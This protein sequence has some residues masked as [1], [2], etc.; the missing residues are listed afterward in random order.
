M[1]TRPRSSLPPW[2]AR[3][4]REAHFGWAVLWKLRAAEPEG[5]AIGTWSVA[6]ARY[7]SVNC[8]IGMKKGFLRREKKTVYRYQRNGGRG[9]FPTE[10]FR[11]TISP[12]YLFMPLSSRAAL[13]GGNDTLMRLEVQQRRYS[14]RDL[15]NDTSNYESHPCVFWKC[16]KA[17]QWKWVLSPWKK[18]FAFQTH[19][20]RINTSMPTL[21]SSLLILLQFSHVTHLQ[22]SKTILWSVETVTKVQKKKDISKDPVLFLCRPKEPLKTLISNEDVFRFNTGSEF[23]PTMLGG[24]HRNREW[25]HQPA[26]PTESMLGNVFI[27][28][29]WDEKMET[30]P[31]NLCMSV[32]K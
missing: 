6:L 32:W 24:P 9:E 22:P 18:L 12:L 19:R 25:N 29:E 13:S 10:A 20:A 3:C 2:T 16:I 5:Q 8:T 30:H 11:W 4:E 21:L 23:Q 31:P 14:C 27:V 26:I 15:D 28:W 17:C 7:I 1:S